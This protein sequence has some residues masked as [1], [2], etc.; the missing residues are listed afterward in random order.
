MR[1]YR[2]AYRSKLSPNYTRAGRRANFKRQRA[3]KW[4]NHRCQIRKLLAPQ[5]PPPLSHPGVSVQFSLGR[6]PC[7]YLLQWEQLGRL[8]RYLAALGVPLS[9]VQKIGP[10]PS[11]ATLCYSF[12]PTHIRNCSFTFQTCTY[13]TS[14]MLK[15]KM[16]ENQRNYYFGC[17]KQVGLS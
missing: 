2:T 1:L 13:R 15:F 12:L 11:S 6:Q 16:C 4:G 14:Q 9:L 10:T 17:L 3:N 8:W 5:S 7:R